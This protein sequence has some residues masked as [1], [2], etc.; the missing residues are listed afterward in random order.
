MI[1]SVNILNTDLNFWYLDICDRKGKKKTFWN[2]LDMKKN[3][4]SQ[5]N[6]L[7]VMFSKLDFYCFY[8]N[9]NKILIHILPHPRWKPVTTS[10]V[11]SY[12]GFQPKKKKKKSAFLNFT[13]KL[14]TSK[15]KVL[16]K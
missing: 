11:Y 2:Q 1:I 16:N 9:I 12:Y 13:P 4:N 5:I 14:E 15:P 7:F 8:S 3:L 6:T 10:L